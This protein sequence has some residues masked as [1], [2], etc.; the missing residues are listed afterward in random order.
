MDR[1]RDTDPLDPDAAT[2]CRLLADPAARELLGA[3]DEPRTARA[4]TEASDLSESTVYRKLDALV[5][6][7]LVTER[8]ALRGDGTHP[9]QFR[10]AVEDLR[11]ELTG[12]GE[13]TAT[14]ETADRA[15]EGGVVSPAA[16]D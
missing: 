15:D 9:R 8:Y 2:L 7:G 10:L 16:S 11:V 6:A 13:L 3:L 4:L 5:D 14:V 1:T 12:A